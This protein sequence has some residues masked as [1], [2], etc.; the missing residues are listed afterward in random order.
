LIEVQILA[1]PVVKKLVGE[2][3]GKNFVEFSLEG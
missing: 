2:F 3:W 1:L